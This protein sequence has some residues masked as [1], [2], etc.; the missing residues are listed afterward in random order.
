VAGANLR[1]RAVE[2][3]LEQWTQRRQYRLVDFNVRLTLQRHN[4][5]DNL[6]PVL[7]EHGDFSPEI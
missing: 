7:T 3:A 6:F 5:G 1:E 2:V 4:I